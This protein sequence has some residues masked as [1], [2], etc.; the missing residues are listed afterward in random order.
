MDDDRRTTRIDPSLA[1]LLT[2]LKSKSKGGKPETDY[3]KQERERLRQAARVR[4]QIDID[5]EI[6]DRVQALASELQV[7]VSQVYAFL[8]W[9]A[10]EAAGRGEIDF[11]EHTYGS[12]SPKYPYNLRIPEK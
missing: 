7:P 4:V 2:D 6:K 1:S 10:L 11:S 9:H 3:E 12:K 8:V 5:P